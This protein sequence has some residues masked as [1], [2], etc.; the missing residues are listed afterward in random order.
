MTLEYLLTLLMSGL[1]TGS[2][3]TV[4]ALGLTMVYGILNLM[5]FAH[6]EVFMVGAYFGYFLFAVF[7]VSYPVAILGAVVGAVATGIRIEAIAFRPLRNAPQLSPLI[8]SLGVSI[9]LQ[10]LALL[11]WSP[12]P[13][14]FYTPF[15]DQVVRIFVIS[16]SMQRVIVF[17]VCVLLIVALYFVVQTTAIGKAMRAVALDAEAAALMGID[18]RKVVIATFAIG[19][20]LAGVAGALVGPILILSPFMG[21]P[22][23]LKA[24]AVVIMGGFGSIQG[25]VLAGFILG[26][27]ESFGVLVIPTAYIDT[28]A[29]VLLIGTLLVR[30][31]GLFAERLE[32]NV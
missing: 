15:V 16:M 9:F 23:I 14:M 18:S 2:V 10:N 20:A 22:I 12:T 28:I 31:T 3:Y 29:F 25:T 4:T 24:F 8:A 17:V 11:L 30:P 1:V 13:R 19:A 21:I 27:T 7:G 32:E 6:G 5:N 26:L